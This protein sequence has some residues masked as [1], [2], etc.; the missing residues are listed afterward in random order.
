M[1]SPARSVSLGLRT[2][3]ALGL[4]GALAV[5]LLVQ[6][7]SARPAKIGAAASASAGHKCLVMTGSGDPAFTRNFNPYA[8][9]MTCGPFFPSRLK[10][11][12]YRPLPH[13]L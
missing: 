6:S 11:G 10:R 13:E 2:A 1:K 7:A 5:A 8:G 9:G 4:A 3:G 12:S